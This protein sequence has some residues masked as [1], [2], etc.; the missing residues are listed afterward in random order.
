MLAFNARRLV[1]DVILL[2]IS[3][4]EFIWLIYVSSCESSSVTFLPDST[5]SSACF[6]RIPT[7]AFPCAMA[8]LF[9]FILSMIFSVP[10]STCSTI[11]WISSVWFN[12]LC[13]AS[14][15]SL[16]P[17][18][19][20]SMDSFIACMLSPSDAVFCALS[21]ICCVILSDVSIIRVSNSSVFSCSAFNSASFFWFNFSATIETY[22][23]IPQI[24][25]ITKNWIS[26][27]AISAFV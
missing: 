18:F 23:W 27:D 20:S 19:T 7:F 4:I 11:A 1:C 2:I 21:V 17:E 14:A 8:S 5:V 3:R 15:V 10:F 6:T 26:T 16:E 12:W 25:T 22:S 9:W 24:S 13:T